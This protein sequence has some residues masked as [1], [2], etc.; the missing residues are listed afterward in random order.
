M[1]KNAKDVEFD[2]ESISKTRIQHVV[3][4][5]AWRIAKDCASLILPVRG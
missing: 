3:K 2:V 4:A 1:I 5:Y